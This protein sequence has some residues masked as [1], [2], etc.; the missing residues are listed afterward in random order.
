MKK[1]R[2]RRVVNILS[3]ALIIFKGLCAMKCS[4]QVADLSFSDQE[5]N[6]LLHLAVQENN[7]ENVQK[8]LEYE[9]RTKSFWCKLNCFC[10]NS[11]LVNVKNKNG[12]TPLHCCA[13]KEEID[14]LILLLLVKHGAA[15]D[16][17]NDE[18][19]R[20]VDC[21][22][23]KCVDSEDAVKILTPKEVTNALFSDLG[24]D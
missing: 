19:K 24:L 23:K 9:A 7:I 14:C 12:L 16:V 13:S 11:A 6:T 21:V 3:I 15:L 1:Q 4:Q 22:D 10:N 17:R 18:F 2:I 20:P 8:I 5:G